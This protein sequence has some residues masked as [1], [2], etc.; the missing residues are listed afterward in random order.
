M[1]PT[2]TIQ[3]VELTTI[4]HA[5]DDLD[6][7]QSALTA[8][9]PDSLK[10][11]QLFTRRHLEGHYGNEIATFEAHLAEPKDIE[12]F[13]SFLLQL[14]PQVERQSILQKLE[15]HIDVDGNLYLRLDKQK[16]YRGIARLGQEDPIRIRL[17]FT[18]FGGKPADL[19]VE[20]L[21]AE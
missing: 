21:E 7:V 17:K 13:K 5:T 2:Q 8:I 3:S 9:L 10:G 14:L 18:K 4:A 15:R 11:R 12:A 16:M 1:K 20:Y 19:M 6:K